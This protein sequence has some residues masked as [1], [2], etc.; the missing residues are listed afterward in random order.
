M[1]NNK[2]FTIIELMIAVA[3]IGVLA[4][5]AIPAYANYMDRAKVAEVSSIAGSYKIS[6][7]ECLQDK[8]SACTVA[9][10]P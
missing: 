1:Q 3:I 4:A 9:D 8:G 10:L 2:G 6:V 7:A 5:V